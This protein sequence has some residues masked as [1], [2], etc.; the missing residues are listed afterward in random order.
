MLYKKY[1]KGFFL[2]FFLPFFFT[3]LQAK[4]PQNLAFFQDKPRSVTKDFY[5][6]EYLKSSQCTKQDAQALL[7]QASS[8]SMKLFY[9]FANKLQDKGIEKAATCMKMKTT[10]LLSTLD[11][12]CIAIGLS[13]YDAT[14]LPKPLLKKLAQRLASYK[15]DFFVALLANKDVYKTMIQADNNAFFELFNKVGAKYRREFFD[16]E[17]SLKK[18]QALQKDSRFNTTIQ[19]IV[20]DIHLKNIQKS[21][22]HVKSANPKLNHFS[23]FFLGLNALKFGKKNKA[24]VYFDEAYKKAYKRIDKDKVLFWQYLVTKDK[25]YKQI[26]EKGYGVDIYTLLL[27]KKHNNKIMIAKA[28]EPHP[29]YDEKDPFAWEK[30]RTSLEGKSKEELYALAQIYLYGSSLP[31]FSYIM[32][33][34]SNYKEHYFPTPYPKYLKDFSIPRKALIL[35][36]ARQESRFIP[37]AISRSYALGMMQFMPFLAKAIAKQKKIENFDLEKMFDPKIAYDFANSHLDYLQKYLYNPLFIA[38]AYNGGIGFTKRL[39][40]SGFFQKG[41]YEPYMSME[42]IPYTESREYAKRVVAN[43]I[44]YRKIFHDKVDIQKLFEDL[45]LPKKSDAFRE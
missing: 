29:F 37:T 27:H 18:L 23:L 6:Y 36:I 2:C 16:K 12:E 30:L 3:Y 11:N 21:L 32:A 35:A 4:T 38:Y 33:K 40:L 43:Y 45:L 26:A 14:T 7:A 39:L 44:I 15:Q 9:A 25:K 24:M 22:L 1:G 28:Y 17:I 31:H 19:V 20:T 8:M 10:D 42:L 41:V 34:A 13:V 5:I